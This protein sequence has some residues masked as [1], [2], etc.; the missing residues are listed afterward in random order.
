MGN[1]YGEII[2]HTPKTI[3]A[4]TSKKQEM[5]RIALEDARRNKIN[6]CNHAWGTTIEN[7][8]NTG[9]MKQQYRGGVYYQP[10]KIKSYTQKCKKC[11]GQR[12]KA[13]GDIFWSKVT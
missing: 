1:F 5:E 11:G 12:N 13:A 7:Y 10:K 2:Y 9:P 6:A 4:K 3:D 8:V